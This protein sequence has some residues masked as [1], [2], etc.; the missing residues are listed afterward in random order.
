MF[1]LR[2]TSR[3]PFVSASNDSKLLK[4]MLRNAGTLR[5]VLSS[6]ILSIST[7]IPDTLIYWTN[8]DVEISV[9]W[10]DGGLDT[11]PCQSGEYRSGY[12][13]LSTH[14][15]PRLFSCVLVTN[16]GSGDQERM[17][18]APAPVVPGENNH[19]PGATSLQHRITARLVIPSTCPRTHLFPLSKS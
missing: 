12:S 18:K 7:S 11:V 8:V 15:V 10:T 2:C 3:F 19:E 17:W 6:G 16:E 5:I 14:V 9:Q 1:I 13:R 4:S